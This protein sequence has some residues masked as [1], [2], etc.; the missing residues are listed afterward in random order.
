MRCIIVGSEGWQFRD[1]KKIIGAGHSFKKSYSRYL[2]IDE[3]LQ[4]WKHKGISKLF[5]EDDTEVSLYECQNKSK[6]TGPAK[7]SAFCYAFDRYG[8]EMRKFDKVYDR[9]F[10]EIATAV[11]YLKAEKREESPGREITY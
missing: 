5:N 2:N 1:Y 10:E 6:F 9:A 7:F 3:A 4:Y 8:G 11:Y